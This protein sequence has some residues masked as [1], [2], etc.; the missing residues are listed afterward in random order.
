[1]KERKIAPPL[2]RQT[3]R[4]FS[5]SSTLWKRFHIFCVAP[6]FSPFFRLLC[7][8]ERGD[9]LSSN[10]FVWVPTGAGWESD[11]A[12]NNQP[13]LNT[14]GTRPWE[15]TSPDPTHTHARNHALTHSAFP[16]S[17]TGSCVSFYHLI[18]KYLWKELNEKYT[19]IH[20]IDYRAICD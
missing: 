15:V 18:R 2:N 5:F 12:V 17:L 10:I 8:S 16:F 11:R 1:M 14:H 4:Y 3:G 13:Q 20:T 7:R 9:G 19:I 6:L